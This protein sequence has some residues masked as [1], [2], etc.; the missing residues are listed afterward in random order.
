[1]YG[2]LLCNIINTY[3]KI[4]FDVLSGSWKIVKLL[5]NIVQRLVDQ[6][7]ICS[8]FFF[9]FILIKIFPLFFHPKIEAAFLILFSSFV[10]FVL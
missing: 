6:M 8:W 1:M 5:N 4:I 3:E 9:L 10:L 7:P 2:I